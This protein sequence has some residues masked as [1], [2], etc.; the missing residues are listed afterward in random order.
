[1]S[2]VIRG[3]ALAVLL[4]LVG[5]PDNAHEKE[6]PKDWTHDFKGKTI[7]EVTTILGEPTESASAKGYLY[8][9]R[10]N[11]EERQ[12]L[13]LVCSIECSLDEKPSSILYFLYRSG[14]EKFIYSRELIK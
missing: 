8:W 7:R 13:K 12:V 3:F 6:I 14:N 1:M 4:V 11:G 9:I 2:T 10:Q 5:C